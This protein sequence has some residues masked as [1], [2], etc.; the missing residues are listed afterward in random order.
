M[1]IF[2]R[3]T[4][5]ILALAGVG[6]VL[7]S[8]SRY[9]IGVSPD[10][11][12]Y[13]SAARN[14]LAGNGL[15]RCDGEWYTAWPPLFPLCLAAIGLVGVDPAA[16]A[17]FLNAFA[18][19]AVVFFSGML[20]ERGL[21]SKALAVVGTAAVL[22]VF[23]LTGVSIMAWT[24]PVFVL[25]IVSFV[26]CASAFLQDP[27]PSRLMAIAVIA[28]LCCMQRYTGVVLIAGGIILIAFFVP[29]MNMRRR[30]AF[31]TIFT[32]VSCSLPALWA[33][34]NYRL[35][36]MF[37]GN[38]RVASIYSLGENVNYGLNVV[39]VWFLPEAIPLWVRGAVL[40]AL[41]FLAVGAIVLSRRDRSC[42][43]P[44]IVALLLYVPMMVYTHQVGVLDE[45]L[46]D[47]YLCPA[48]VLL[49]YLLF[50]A[51][52]RASQSIIPV[53]LA[54][55]WLVYPASVVWKS[56][57]RQMRDGAGGYSTTFWRQ[58]PVVQW[59]GRHPLKGALYSNSPPAI[60]AL[61]GVNAGMFLRRSENPDAFK[62]RLLP[63]GN[64]YLIW[65][66]RVGGPRRYPLDELMRIFRIEEVAKL[67]DGGIYRIGEKLP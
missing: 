15:K 23:V 17:R 21:R 34:R 31:L 18:L 55:I 19:G 63:D 61:T 67:S 49:V 38:E 10:S 54:A 48:S 51:L 44:I 1:K 4:I 2:V 42:L 36:S 65:F 59:L 6:V 56:T 46:N 62:Q 9:G 12:N 24:E 64:N 35:T 43:W 16:G 32:A 11:T 47:R 26:F 5:V 66:N 29:G 39:S 60:Y 27:K 57:T 58:S 22:L 52:D 50:M 30:I 3:A 41:L 7:L 53:V 40:A 25:L 13:I 37:S 20:L 33:I 8:T 28:A 14:L 45:T